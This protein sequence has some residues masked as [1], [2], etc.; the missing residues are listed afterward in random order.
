MTNAAKNRTPKCVHG[1]EIF[2][3]KGHSCFE[4]EKGA[5][6]NRLPIE[7]RIMDGANAML[8]HAQVQETE[9]NK[10]NGHATVGAPKPALEAPAADPDPL[11]INGTPWTGEALR[12]L[13][14][15]LARPKDINGDPLPTRQPCPHEA[16]RDALAAELKALQRVVIDMRRELAEVS[17]DRDTFARENFHLVRTLDSVRRIVNHSTDAG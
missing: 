13:M 12:R 11:R 17:A 3:N 16:E 14:A 6:H 4:C 8:L 9:R 7:A 5:I 1:V 10:S 2:L 15:D